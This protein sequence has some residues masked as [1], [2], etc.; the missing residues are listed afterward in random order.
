MG[1]FAAAAP[2]IAAGISAAGSIGGSMMSAQGAAGAN[3]ANV[4][5]QSE[6]NRS[7]L[8]MEMAKHE[9]NTAFMEDQQSFNREE[10]QYAEQFNEGQAALTRGWSS[11]EA[12]RQMDFQ[13]RMAGNQMAF[14][15]RMANTAYQRAMADMRSAGLN[16]ILAYQQGGAPMGMGSAPSGAMGSANTASSPGASSGMAS[17]G[18]ASGNQRAGHVI[19]DK[20]D[21]GRALGNIVN[22]AVDAAKTVAGVDQLQETTELTKEQTRRVGYETGQLDAQTGKTLADTNVSKQQ[23]QNLQIENAILRANAVT[24]VQN[25]RT[26]R[27]DADASERYGGKYAPGTVERILRSVQDSVERQGSHGS[28][29]DRTGVGFG[30]FK[31]KD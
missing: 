26:A 3:A 2:L 24:A 5:M 11:Q 21:M 29:W 31:R 10:R 19:N 14:Q 16:P 8:A 27:A 22:S 17:S 7:N 15:E 6:A 4:A 23:E 18:S 28:A 20:A 30:G 1:F 25:A 12:G 13:E 9:Q